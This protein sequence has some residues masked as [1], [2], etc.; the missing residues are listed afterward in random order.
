MDEFRVLGEAVK[1]LVSSEETG[2][3][4]TTLTQVSPPGGGPPPHSHANEDETFYV[5]EGEYELLLNGNR[6]RLR[7]GDAAHAPRGSIHTFRNAG[8]TEGK[9]LIITVPGGFE[10]YLEEISR[11]SIPQDMEQLFEIS[12]RYGISFAI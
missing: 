11:L 3:A 10:K 8:A 2:G 5:L 1:I 4:S 7:P 12:K 6:R 9:L